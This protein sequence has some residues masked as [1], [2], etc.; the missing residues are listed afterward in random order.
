MTDGDAGSGA[1]AD[2]GR[3]GDRGGDE[4]RADGSRTKGTA[5]EV[6][7][8]LAVDM[9]GTIIL[10]DTTVAGARWIILH[11]PWY[12]LLL[13]LWEV[14]PGRSSW[15]RHLAARVPFDPTSLRYNE[16]F[17]HW[18]R[19]Q[20]ESGREIILVTA[21]DEKPAA[22]VAKHFGDLFDDVL[23][24]DGVTNLHGRNKAAALDARWGRGEY[25][26]AG[27]SHS[28]LK[29]WPHAGE[30]IVVNPSRGVL[31]RLGREP[32]LLFE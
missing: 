10:T 23:A 24:S 1:P 14:W 15:K 30:V 8:P 13:P 25:A 20:K 18:L 6:V 3:A 12:V 11:R 27:N 26:Y 5:G 31:R 16:P 21:S 4:V 28:D 7:L 17:L 2:A 9:D 29:V 22:A 32:D 19:E